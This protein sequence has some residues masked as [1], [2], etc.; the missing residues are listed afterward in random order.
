MLTTTYQQIE[1]LAAVRAGR[2][3]DSSPTNLKLTPAEAQSVLDALADEL[4]EVWNREAWPETWGDIEAV[5]LDAQNCF[6]KRLTSVNL[7]ESQTWPVGLFIEVPGFV[8]GENYS[9]D[10]GNATYL[11]LSASTDESEIMTNEDFTATQTSYWIY[12]TTAGDEVTTVI[13]LLTGRPMG[14]ILAIVSGGDPRTNNA[15]QTLDRDQWTELDD[16]VNVIASPLGSLY[17]DW[18]T[19]VPDLLSVASADL[20][21]YELPRRFRNVLAWLGAAMLLEDE[22]P[23]R[24]NKCR[25]AA[26]LD[27]LKQA[28]RIKK[29]WWRK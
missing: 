8:I 29:P 20:A 3:D 6:S 4:P 11:L 21:A 12:K 1:T 10:L 17:V 16:L 28:T 13:E 9:L 27:L 2:A 19:P 14:D 18:Q 23:A 15:V 22:D 26:E 24:A 25:A 7:V 5:E